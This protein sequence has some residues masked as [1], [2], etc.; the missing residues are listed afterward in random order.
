MSS[1]ALFLSTSRKAGTVRITS[2]KCRCCLHFGQYTHASPLMSSPLV[3]QAVV[4]G[5]G[6]KYLTALITLSIEGGI[7]FAKKIGRTADTYED[8]LAMEDLRAEIE[9]HVL[10]INEKFS[11]VEQIKKFII[12]PRPLSIEEG[13]LT[14]LNK[15][16]RY[17]VIEKYAA[18]VD[19]LYA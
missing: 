8:L 1:A 7:S 11:R 18:E 2:T 14:A 10:K 4:A 17:V 3:E 15:I 19:R 13:E 6:R 5:D 12:L 9:K 16:K